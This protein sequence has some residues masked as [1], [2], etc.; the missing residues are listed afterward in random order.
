M[1]RRQDLVILLDWKVIWMSF[2][3]TPG[4]RS[5]YNRT[6]RDVGTH[7]RVATHTDGLC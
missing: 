3:M 4:N 2:L 7:Y 5:Y 1:E 6:G